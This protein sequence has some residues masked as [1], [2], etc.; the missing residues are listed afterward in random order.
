MRLLLKQET[1]LFWI[2]LSFFTRLPV[3]KNLE[4]S[5]CNLNKA[6]RYFSLVGWLVGI[7]CAL[8]FYLAAQIVSIP[9]AVILSMGFS[10][11]LTGGFHED[12]LADTAD[13]LGGGWTQDQKLKIMKDSRLGSYG[14]LALWFA[15]SLKFVLLSE[16]GYTAVYA[17]IIAHPLSRVMSTIIIA[18]LPYVSEESQSKIKPLAEKMTLS[19]LAIIFVIGCLPLIG[20]IKEAL[21][22]LAA[23]LLVTLLFSW[24]LKKQIRGFTGDALGATQQLT[25]LTIYLALIAT[26]ALQ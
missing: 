23:V 1:N 3:P 22:V 26:G 11:L 25:E 5:Q 7:S 9:V 17:L 20:I 18:G 6:S 15:L 12:G 14:A 16:L 10:F 8:I 13:G 19:D 4:F 21:I 24:Y 2:A